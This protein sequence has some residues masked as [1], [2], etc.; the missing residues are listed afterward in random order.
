[1][2]SPVA[3]IQ[4]TWRSPPPFAAREGPQLG[5]PASFVTRGLE[6]GLWRGVHSGTT[7]GGDP[8]PCHCFCGEVGGGVRTHTH[9]PPISA[10]SLFSASNPLTLNPI[11]ASFA[12]SDAVC[13]CST[14][15]E[16]LGVIP[17]CYRRRTEVQ[18]QRDCL[19]QA[20]I[21]SPWQK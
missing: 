13:P 12:A 4:G 7:L 19:A 11:L 2:L 6:F 9:T 10:P 8:S 18:R 15:K 5:H 14:A 17:L 21:A 1:V 16:N 3:L 20:H